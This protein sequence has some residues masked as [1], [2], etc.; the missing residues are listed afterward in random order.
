MEAWLVA[1]GCA[2]DRT[3]RLSTLRAAAEI[4]CET[5]IVVVDA[6]DG[7]LCI[8][9]SGFGSLGYVSVRSSCPRAETIRFECLVEL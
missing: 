5:F 1:I 3:D 6:G 7:A 8:I 9:P 4:P 2:T